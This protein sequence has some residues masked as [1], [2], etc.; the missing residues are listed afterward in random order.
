MFPDGD[1]PLVLTRAYAPTAVL[2]P[3]VPIVT[4][5]SVTTNIN[6]WPP[7]VVVQLV[8]L[9]KPCPTAVLLTV[10][11]CCIEPDSPQPCC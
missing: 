8:I 4:G 9:L 1:A 10:Q 6:I 7:N 3:V 2:V 5:P 11:C